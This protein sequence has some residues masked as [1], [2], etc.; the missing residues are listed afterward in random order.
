M[1]DSGDEHAPQSDLA[2]SPPRATRGRLDRASRLARVVLI[3]YVLFLFW[4]AVANGGPEPSIQ[5]EDLLRLRDWMLGILTAGVLAGVRLLLLGFLVSFSAGYPKAPLRFS[6]AVARWLSVALVGVLLLALLSLAGSAGL[7]GVAALVFPLTGYLLGA[8]IGFTCLRG[9]RATLWLVP[10]LGLLVLALGA[11][12]VGLVFLA[13]DD[14]PLPFQ[15]PRVT[16]AEKRRLADVVES[17]RPAE[18]GFRR[19]RLSQRDVNLLLALAMGQALSE[20]KARIAL[21]EGAVRGDLSLKVADSAAPPRYINVH[22]TCRGEVTDGRPELRFE[23][24]RIGRVSAPQFLLDA[25]SPLLIAGVLDDPDFKHILAAIVS[26]RVEP[27]GV[28]AVFRSGELSDKVIPSLLARLG[29]K[30]DVL[31]RTRIHFRHLVQIAPELPREDRFR[32]FLQAAFALA[33]ERSQ[34]ENPVLENRAAVLALAILLGHRRVETLVGSVTDEDL[35]IAARRHVRWVTLRDRR[36]WSRHFLVSAALALLSNES[37]SDEVGLFKEEFDAG[38]GGSGFSFAD[39]LADRAGTLFALAATR[40]ERSAR[41]MQDRMTAQFTIDE[42]FPPA[43]D[44]PE[45]IPD[46]ELQTEYGGVGG[47]KYNQV[48][49]ELE[50]RLAT[51]PALR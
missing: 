24:C 5:L 49:R 26:V 50:R 22:A 46:L 15:P 17:S 28:E 51:C 3:G 20:G 13:V 2:E 23:A 6:A 43:A 44:L 47:E 9:P 8:W 12:V 41:Q 11:G 29:Q 7:P 4:L 30:P 31:M 32:A 45:G 35:Q 18:N 10:K 34:A 40:D 21:E 37:L 42:V 16:S 39:L 14:E 27:E 25:L 33:R 38:E 19:L 36:D 1:P 48:L